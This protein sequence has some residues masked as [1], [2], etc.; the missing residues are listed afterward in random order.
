MV[1][2]DDHEAAYG[3]DLSELYQ[4]SQAW[5]EEARYLA[6]LLATV[7]RYDGRIA[8][9]KEL[10]PEALALHE[11]THRIAERLYVYAYLLDA[12]KGNH[13]LLEQMAGL[14]ADLTQSWSF[15]PSELA[16]LEESVVREV[17]TSSDC[18]DR[19][20]ILVGS[21]RRSARHLPRPDSSKKLL[22]WAHEKERVRG[23]FD[24]M[25]GGSLDLGIIDTPQGPEH[26]SRAN[27]S[28]FLVH[29]SSAIRQ[30]AYERFFH[31]LDIHKEA[32]AANLSSMI[33]LHAEEARLHGH[34]S[35]R[36]HV[37]FTDTIEPAV[38]DTLITTIRSQLPRFHAYFE[39]KCRQLRTD[40]IPAW[41]LAVPLRQ[42]YEQT[43]SYDQAVDLVC[44]SLDMFG[45]SYT[46]K[47]HDCLCGSWIDWQPRPGKH[48][49]SFTATCYG[50]HPWILCNYKPEVPRTLHTLA[51][52]SAHAMHSIHSMEHNPFSHYGYAVVVAETVAQVHE[53]LLDSFL[54]ER[55][56]GNENTGY[57]LEQQLEGMRLKLLRQTMLAEFEHALHQR[58]VNTLEEMRILYR[59]LLHEY[60]GPKVRFT[61]TSD[62]E[63]LSISHLYQPYYVYTYPLGLC[64][65][66]VIAHPIFAGDAKAIKAYRALLESG[67]REHPHQLL[68]ASG[69]DIRSPRLYS[70]VCKQ[71]SETLAS[72]RLALNPS[73]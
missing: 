41:D 56:D 57:L 72:Y 44:S 52:E 10:L 28:R 53:L 73:T 13:A 17:L 8:T 2:T 64:A 43:P 16:S 32:L 33:A 59:K 58:S 29:P 47:V 55:R 34:E 21:L 6:D 20:G 19:F 38:H 62:L 65:A 69:A 35:T 61:D 36:D 40:R 4:D 18:L 60:H 63:F 68:A 5:N 45:D 24:S 37:L 9:R 12:S 7:A 30:Q 14:Q 31:A 54:L 50:Y 1:H 23:S 39:E 70:T 27:L 11:Q 66:S 71:F 42:P 22:A 49:G 15:L 25:M 48:P 46:G 26:L 51:H 3:W 67:T